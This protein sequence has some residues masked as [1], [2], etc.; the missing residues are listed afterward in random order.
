M[1]EAPVKLRGHHLLCLLPYIGLGYTPAFIENFNAIVDSINRGV[2]IEITDGP[3]AIC[4]A[5]HAGEHREFDDCPTAAAAERDRRA[6]LQITEHLNTPITSGAT[7][8]LT[9]DMVVRLRA[10]FAKGAIRHACADCEWHDICTGIA[11]RDYD[12]AKLF[13]HAC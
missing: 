3:D 12:G 13:P 9:P 6:L 8:T 2:P 5:L 4:K 10:L 11:A 7:L 1:A